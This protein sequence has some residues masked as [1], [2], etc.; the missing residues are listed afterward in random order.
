MT[1]WSLVRDGAEDPKLSARTASVLPSSPR[2][3]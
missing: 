3:S 2:R 1:S